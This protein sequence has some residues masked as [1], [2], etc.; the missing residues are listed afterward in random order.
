ML[1]SEGKIN[2]KSERNNNDKKGKEGIEM[3]SDEK[4]SGKTFFLLRF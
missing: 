1:F 2:S 3:K 4:E